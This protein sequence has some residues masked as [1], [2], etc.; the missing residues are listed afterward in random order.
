MLGWTGYVRTAVTGNAPH[1][2]TVVQAYRHGRDMYSSHAPHIFTAVVPAVVAA[3]TKGKAF[4]QLLSH[5]NSERTGMIQ[6]STICDARSTV[7]D[8]AVW[9]LV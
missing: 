1:I 6:Q 3:Q 7:Y 9:Y 5:T 2:L 4:E 8:T